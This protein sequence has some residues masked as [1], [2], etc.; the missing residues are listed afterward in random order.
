MATSRT[1][2][3]SR[4]LRAM[5]YGG[6]Y[7]NADAMTTK[8][9]KSVFDSGGESVVTLKGRTDC[10][11]NR[12]GHAGRGTA[13]C[14]CGVKQIQARPAQEAI[15][16]SGWPLGTIPTCPP[17]KRDGTNFPL[18]SSWLYR[19]GTNAWVCQGGQAATPAAADTMD[20]RHSSDTPP[21]PLGSFIRAHRCTITG[22]YLSALRTTRVN[23]TGRRVSDAVSRTRAAGV[24]SGQVGQCGHGR[25]AGRAPVRTWAE[26]SPEH[27]PTNQG[28]LK[29]GS[30][31]TKQNLDQLGQKNPS[32]PKISPAP[33]R[34]EFY[35][36]GL[37]PG[38]T[39][40]P[41][42][43]SD[44]NAHR[45]KS[46]HSRQVGQ[47]GKTNEVVSARLMRSLLRTT[48]R[49]ESAL[50]KGTRSAACQDSNPGP[51]GSES[52]ALSTEP[53]YNTGSPSVRVSTVAVRASYTRL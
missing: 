5:S 19:V 43:R 50:P 12:I 34:L 44:P 30:S 52:S 48:T 3:I 46:Q 49:H 36:K 1:D 21:V 6:R 2:V 15:C 27:Q 35:Q 25:R 40:G 51:L 28:R 11:G 53:V 16:L 41:T 47:I 10:D 38:G 20:G 7:G 26:P 24:A 29:F 13:E 4:R 42:R 8:H 23:H 37:G 18:T 9:N 31:L 32:R 17:Y 22:R 39:A 33:R 45:G 14:S